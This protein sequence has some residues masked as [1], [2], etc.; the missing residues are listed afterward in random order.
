MNGF[1][2]SI[3]LLAE[4]PAWKHMGDAFN[5]KNAA[6]SQSEVLSL[7][8][9]ALGAVALIWLLHS[10][11]NRVQSTRT[12]NRPKRLFGQLCRAHRLRH[13]D[14]KL[15]WR[16]AEHLRHSQPA[17]LFIRPDD[18]TTEGL[19]ADLEQHTREITELRRRLFAT[20]A[21]RPK[22]SPGG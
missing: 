21:V 6:L 17:M 19:P 3:L 7:A 22:S 18:F 1:R 11:A 9:L 4:M 20:D 10:Y 13:K 5:K 2:G 12:Y 14:R 8:G 16:L 15:L